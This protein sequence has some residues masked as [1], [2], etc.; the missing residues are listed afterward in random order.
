MLQRPSPT[1]RTS[2]V[3]PV[4]VFNAAKTLTLS[5]PDESLEH[6]FECLHSTASQPPSRAKG[7]EGAVSLLGWTACITVARLSSRET[8]GIGPRITRVRLPSHQCLA[9]PRRFELLTFAFG[10]QRSIQLSYGRFARFNTRSMD[11]GQRAPS[12]LTIPPTEAS[13]HT[14][15]GNALRTAGATTVP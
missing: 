10:G 4:F 12:S 11:A 3:R 5:C 6:S 2:A 15:L 13:R 8:N 1:G 14:F 9:R 7:L